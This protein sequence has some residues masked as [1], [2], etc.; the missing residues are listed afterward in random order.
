[1]LDRVLVFG[2]A[3]STQALQLAEPELLLVALMGQHVV[4]NG[5][6]HDQSQRLAVAAERLDLQLMLGTPL[7][8]PVIV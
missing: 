4:G 3:W 7:P 6:R 1:M 5:R 2:M 8:A